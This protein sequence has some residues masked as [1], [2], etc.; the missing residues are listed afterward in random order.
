MCDEKK[1]KRLAYVKWPDEKITVELIC[2][3]KNGCGFHLNNEFFRKTIEYDNPFGTDMATEDSQG[4]E[5]R[6][7][8][9]SRETPRWLENDTIKVEQE[10]EHHYKK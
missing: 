8:L 7:S 5:V 9:L 4:N 2:L 6:M 3:G 1:D 10:A